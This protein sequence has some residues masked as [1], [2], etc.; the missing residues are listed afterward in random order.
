MARRSIEAFPRERYHGGMRIA[1]DTHTH[2]V[3]SGHAYSTVEEMT[4]AAR[5]RRLA[6]FVLTD[7]GPAMEGTTHRYH[8]GNLRALPTKMYGVRLYRGVEANV[9]DAEGR[10]DLDAYYLEKLDFVLAGLHEICL[11]PGAEEE[12]TRALEA[13]LANPYVDSVS[14]PGNPSYPVDF[15]RV[16]KAARDNGKCLELNDSSRRIRKGSDPGCLAIAR[17]CARLGARVSCGSDAHWSGD[18]GRLDGAASLAA[19]AGIPKA[20]I[21]NASLDSFEGFLEERRARLARL[22]PASH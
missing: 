8:F 4:R 16:V 3:A 11:A 17:L 1:I 6:G 21:V 9:M 20:L 22:A 5:R 18:V 14:H 2:S 15:E 7:H 10:V 12:N 13:V 19:E